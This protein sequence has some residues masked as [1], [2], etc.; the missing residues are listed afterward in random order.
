MGNALDFFQTLTLTGKKAIIADRILK[1]ITERL[2][3]L[4]NVGLP[5]LT[6]DRAANTLSGGESQ[7]IRL[8]TQI[9]SKLTGVLY[10]L[11]EPSIGLHQRD[12]QQLLSALSKMRDL[13]NTV[14]VVEHDEETIRRADHVVDMGPGAGVEGGH[15][16]FSGTPEDL[17]LS[18]TSL[19]GRYLSGKK[20]I[21]IP[22]R[23]RAGHGTFLGIKGAT[24]NNLKNIDVTFPLGQ[25]ICVT[26]VSGSGKSS[27]VLETL[28][29][30]LSQRL[31][32]KKIRAGRFSQTHRPGAYRQSDPY[33]S[34]RHRQ[35]AT[36]ES[37]NLYGFVY[38][39]SGTFFQNTGIP[40]ARLQTRTVQF[41]CQRRKVRSLQRGR[42]H[43]D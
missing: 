41:Q 38:F 16:V 8:A 10:V 17:M 15:V 39:H 36:I 23:R 43:Q 42:Y 1:E 3:F 5:Y 6:L 31:Y 35:N 11:D 14:V 33:R 25:L 27:L 40:N 13:G 12:N 9:G 28:F 18:E 24:Q 26:G 7:R 22:M 34:V 29:R 2:G 20:T 37:G 30:A 4:V 19:T 32:H 21:D